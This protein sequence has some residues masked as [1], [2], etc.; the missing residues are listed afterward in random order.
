MHLLFFPDRQDVGVAE[1]S[2]VWV[3]G[4]NSPSYKEILKSRQ[5]VMRIDGDTRPCLVPI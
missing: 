2:G 5:D 4:A 1:R 3:S